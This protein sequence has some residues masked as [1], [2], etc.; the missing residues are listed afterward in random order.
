MRGLEA[1][2]EI[3]P[4]G[5]LQIDASGSYLKFGYLASSLNPSTGILPSM[6]TP[7]TPKWKWSAGV[8]YA[9][10]VGNRGSLTP[11]IDVAYQDSVYSNAVNGPLNQIPAYT[12]A[13][14]RLTW[15]SAT[16]GWEA[17][18]EVTNLTNKLYY[19]TTFDL[20][21]AGGGSV[22]GQP[23]MPREWSFSLKKSF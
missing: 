22:A 19:L 15:R 10:D 5:G 17:A 20:T 7:Y 13:N 6:S 3:H 8:Q 11:R 18:V 1:E 4:F 9:F 21:G 12:T 2:T 16:G 23:A 14:A